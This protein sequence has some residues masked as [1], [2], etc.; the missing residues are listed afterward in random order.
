MSFDRNI[1]HRLRSKIES[2]DVSLLHMRNYLFSRQCSLLLLLN[3]PWEVA[4]RSL[5]FPHNTVQVSS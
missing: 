3:K 5:F 1:N 2:R 4:K